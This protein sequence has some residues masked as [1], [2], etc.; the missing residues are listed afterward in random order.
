[1]QLIGCDQMRTRADEFFLIACESDH[2]IILIIKL[3]HK[4]KLEMKSYF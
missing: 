4:F 2:L 1:M 3:K